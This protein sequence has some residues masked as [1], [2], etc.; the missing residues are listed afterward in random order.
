M[1]DLEVVKRFTDCW[2]GNEYYS[3]HDLREILK[4]S[5]KDGCSSCFL[6]WH[7]QTLIGVRLSLA[8]SHWMNS[9]VKSYPELWNIES[10]L[11]GYF[12]SLFIHGEFRGQGIG[13]KLSDLAIAILRRQG[14]KAIVTHSWLESP[15]NSSQSYLLAAG[16][17]EVGRHQRFWEPIDYHCLRCGPERCQCTAVEMIKLI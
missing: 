1:D 11:V 14:A 12:K 16:F 10:H 3:E 2:I 5:S 8:P 4:Q 17:T 7:G 13:K 6:A 15:D 9:S